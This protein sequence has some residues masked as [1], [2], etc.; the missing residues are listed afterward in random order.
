[1]KEIANKRPKREK[2]IYLAP[3]EREEPIFW[4][5]GVPKASPK[6]PNFLKHIL[7]LF[8]W[9]ERQ[10]HPQFHPFKVT[11]RD[12]KVYYGERTQKCH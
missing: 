8:C 7:P 9:L 6:Q 1:M 3:T 10:T 2:P 11:E 5:T 12:H 4:R